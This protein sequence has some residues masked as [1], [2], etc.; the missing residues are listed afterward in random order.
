MNLSTVFLW[1]SHT[2]LCESHRAQRGLISPNTYL[3][4]NIHS[5]QEDTTGLAVKTMLKNITVVI[6]YKFALW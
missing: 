6:Y 2:S 3:E 5:V 4:I 1:T